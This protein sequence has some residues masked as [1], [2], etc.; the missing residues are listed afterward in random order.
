MADS[1][2]AQEMMDAAEA[3]KILDTMAVKAME[4]RV[5]AK[6]EWESKDAARAIEALHTAVKGDPAK[7]DIV[8]K[9]GLKPAK[10]PPYVF[11]AAATPPGFSPKM[12]GE[13]DISPGLLD[14]IKRYAPTSKDVN[15]YV[16]S[17]DPY[18]PV[19]AAEKWAPEKPALSP[20]WVWFSAAF[21]WTPTQLEDFPVPNFT[22]SD[23]AEQIR[24]YIP[25]TLPNGGA[26]EW[27]KAATERLCF[28]L[29]NQN[30]RTLLH[31]PTGAGK[32]TLV[33]AVAHKLTI[34]LIRVNCHPDMQS[35]DFLGK[36][37]IKATPH[38]PVLEYDWSLTTLAAK[39]GGIL[40]IDEAFRSPCLMA[41]QAL[42]ERTGT[43]TLPDAAS[44]RPEDRRIT[45]PPDAFWIALTDNTV[46]MGDE[47]GAYIAEVQ[48][49]STLDRITAVVHIPYMTKDEELATLKAMFPSVTLPNKELRQIVDWAARI[50]AGF[51][52]KTFQHSLSPRGTSSILRKFLATGNMAFAVKAGFLDK[53]TGPELHA[54][55]EAW[56][57]VNG[58]ELVL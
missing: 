44:L 53:L 58:K 47:S 55:K 22:A 54:A 9:G 29:F 31:G 42:L 26:W 18:I 41:I 25:D 39:H 5:A 7:G 16:N 30:D 8:K 13:A 38:G 15:D 35:T 32:S 34:P 21:G 37:I 3:K 56:Y 17:A 10:M 1:K 43:L 48:D 20:G 12:V 49:V 6:A 57:S 46:G 51:L 36:D 23:W 4:A 19:K 24:W 33:Q 14:A 52:N 28:A 27:P 11:P 2:T 45:P 40:L 50:R